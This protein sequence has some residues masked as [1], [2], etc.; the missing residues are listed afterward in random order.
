[1]RLRLA[2]AIV[3]VAATFGLGVETA[4]A[5]SCAPESPSVKLAAADGAFNGRLLDV[6]PAGGSE[7]TF[8]YRIGQVFKGRKRL[9]RGKTVK[10]HSSA[11][12]SAACAL[13]PDTGKL[14]GLFVYRDRGHWSG[15]SCNVISPR[16]LR[17]AAGG[18]AQASAAASASLCG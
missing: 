11:F 3:T 13:P 4:A 6:T 5:C 18:K 12:G 14:Y 9:R 8:R 1:M 7:A 17:R 16:Q 15:N 2:A 10:V